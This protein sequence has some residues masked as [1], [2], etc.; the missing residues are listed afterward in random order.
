[1]WCWTSASVISSGWVAMRGAVPDRFSASSS[2]RLTRFVPYSNVSARWSSPPLSKSRR[3]DASSSR[4]LRRFAVAHV[5]AGAAAFGFSGGAV[6]KSWSTMASNNSP[7]LRARKRADATCASTSRPSHRSVRPQRGFAATLRASSLRR[8]FESTASA[9]Q[10]SR[11]NTCVAR[12]NNSHAGFAGSVT[13]SSAFN[14][15]S[16]RAAARASFARHVASSATLS[17]AQRACLDG[18]APRRGFRD[19]AALLPSSN[20]SPPANKSRGASSSSPPRKKRYARSAAPAPSNDSAPVC[21]RPRPDIG[22]ALGCALV[23]L[24]TIAHL[25]TR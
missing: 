1:M 19:G 8:R 21:A 4:A 10:A 18:A 5:D 24:E 7:S 12:L 14:R 25:G 11:R 20:K 6:S 23:Q 22:R 13:S 16:T 9:S 15:R 2:S 3:P 17:V